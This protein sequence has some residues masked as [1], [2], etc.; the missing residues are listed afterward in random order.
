MTPKH[1]GRLGLAERSADI[2]SI[3]SDQSSTQSTQGTLGLMSGHFKAFILV[4]VAL[5]FAVPS[6][7]NIFRPRQ[8][9]CPKYTVPPLDLQKLLET[10]LYYPLCTPCTTVSA[11]LTD[12]RIDNYA[13]KFYIRP[14]ALLQTSAAT[15]MRMIKVASATGSS[16]R[17]Q[18]LQ[19]PALPSRSTVSSQA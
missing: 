13:S 1:G 5:I 15:V 9:G 16:F 7:A 4:F 12:F 14:L 11:I 2:S 17:N 19:I 10:R 6:S 18:R 8:G 3:S